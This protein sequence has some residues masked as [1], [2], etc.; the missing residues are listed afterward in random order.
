[1]T[2]A[3]A[4]NAAVETAP[5]APFAP[6]PPAPPLAASLAAPLGYESAINPTRLGQS[7]WGQASF[8]LTGIT[9]LYCVV[10]FIGMTQ[11]RGWDALG[12]LIVGLIGNWVGCGLA[13]I[14]GLVGVLQRRRGRRL[15]AHALWVSLVIGIG[16]IAVMWIGTLR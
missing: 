6:A 10:C 2:G 7:R 13:A 4:T 3:D 8:I 12:W 5:A 16:P 1:M 9:V 15:A 11:A 14:C